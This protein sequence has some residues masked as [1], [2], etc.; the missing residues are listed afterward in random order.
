MFPY[1]MAFFASFN[2]Q[3]LQFMPQLDAV[4]SLYTKFLIAMAAVFQMPTIVF[5][6]AKMNLITARF[7][8]QQFKYAVL[9]TFIISAVITP[10][11]DPVTQTVF[12]APMIGLYV[13][14]IGIAWLVGP[15][16]PS[17]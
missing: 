11:G 4:F 8:I 12:A 13:L 14:G 17:E 16:R 3:D 10:T 1:M 9:L 5:F 2:T 6:L 7:L 15:K